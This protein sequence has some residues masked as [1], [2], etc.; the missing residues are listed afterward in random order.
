MHGTRPRCLLILVLL[1]SLAAKAQLRTGVPVRTV[2]DL[3]TITQH[4]GTIFAGRVVK[5]EPVRIASSGDLASVQ[6]T[7]EV[8]RGL[9]VTNS[10][11]PPNPVMGAR[12][13]FQCM[14]FLPDA[15]GPVEGTGDG[16]GGSGHYPMKVVLGSW[17]AHR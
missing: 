15:P 7:C 12:V 16:D 5:V 2:P 3:G 9:R 13:T 17:Q 8:E 14:T 6:I 4:A 10:A 11:T 1:S